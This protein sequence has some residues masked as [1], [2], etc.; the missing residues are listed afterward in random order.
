V[1]VSS[2]VLS[3]AAAAAWEFCLAAAVFSGVGQ[4][5]ALFCA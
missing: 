2:G 5:K 3:P 1:R 4:Q